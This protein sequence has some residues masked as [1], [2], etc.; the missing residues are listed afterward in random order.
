MSNS[1]CCRRNS[2]S[3]QPLEAELSSEI[4]ALQTQ[5][6]EKGEETNELKAQI[7]TLEG[8]R[9]SNAVEIEQLKGAL[10]N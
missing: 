7:A 8:E 9:A 3:E 10:R 1:N 2:R 5:L 4:A 6:A